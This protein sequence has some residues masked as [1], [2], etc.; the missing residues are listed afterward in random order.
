MYFV[1]NGEKQLP[2]RGTSSQCQ[3]QNR[4]YLSYCP[5]V[6]TKRTSMPVIIMWVIQ[7]MHI[8]PKYKYRNPTM[9]FQRARAMRVWA[10]WLRWKQSGEKY[11]RSGRPSFSE[12][13]EVVR[14]VTGQQ[15]E[16]LA[17]GSSYLQPGKVNFPHEGLQY[18]SEIAVGVIS[19]W[20]NQL[21]HCMLEKWII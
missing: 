13:R 12:N 9:L 18:H 16:C 4:A 21:S 17:C 8:M 6:L 10:F 20:V 7:T 14:V 11:E 2:Q 3:L 19:P 1:I 15:V 5:L